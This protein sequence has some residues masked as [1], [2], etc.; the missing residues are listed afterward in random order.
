MSAQAIAK[1][2][3]QALFE[4]VESNKELNKKTATTAFELDQAA[5]IF[6]QPDS[7]IFFS[8]PFNSTET[9]IMVAKSALEGNC[10]VEIF[11]F[12]VSIV[13]KERVSFLA[14]INESFQALV[15]GKDGETEGVLYVPGE[16]SP[17][18]KAQVEARLTSALNKKVK[19]K[20]EKDPTLLSGYKARVGGW[21]IDDSAQFHLNKIKENISKRGI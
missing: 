2:Y 16:I 14:A 8:S 4:V 3:S 9:K 11:N 5:K 12:L 19:L 13:E 10:S 6:S 15:R 7:L 17:E 20:I 1:K 21:T 18:F